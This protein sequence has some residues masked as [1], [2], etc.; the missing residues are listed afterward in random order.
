MWYIVET[1][2][3]RGFFSSVFKDDKDPN[4]INLFFLLRRGGWEWIYELVWSRTSTEE[5]RHGR[6][7]F[8]AIIKHVEVGFEGFLR[9]SIAIIG[10]ILES[11]KPLILLPGSGATLTLREGSKVELSHTCKSQMGHGTRSGLS[12]SGSTC[13]LSSRDAITKDSYR[14][15]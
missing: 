8:F 2:I 10:V 9:C 12:S 4:G 13:A 3:W 1:N 5:G 14:P 11:L 15:H 7:E 6:S